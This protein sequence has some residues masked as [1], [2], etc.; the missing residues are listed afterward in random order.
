MSLQ[1]DIDR[2]KAEILSANPKQAQQAVSH[3][4]SVNKEVALTYLI[5]LLDSENPALQGTAALGLHDL[6]DNR[7]MEPLF[8]AIIKPE[9]AVCNGILTFALTAL[10][11][12]NKLPQLFDLLFYGNAEVR[13]SVISILNEQIFEFTRSELRAIQTKWQHIQA[14]PEVCP[15]YDEYKDDIG[16]IV[17]WYV[18]YLDE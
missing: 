13:M 12:S 7:A 16:T 3:L 5:S 9:N 11:C 1:E 10:D 15:Y 14:H 4:I 8:K 6:A 18:S 2:L 17:N